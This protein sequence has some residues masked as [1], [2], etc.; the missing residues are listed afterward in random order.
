MPGTLSDE[1]DLNP[2]LQIRK[3]RLGKV[4]Q[5]LQGHTVPSVTKLFA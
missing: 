2:H 3:L 4:K 5:L 1:Y